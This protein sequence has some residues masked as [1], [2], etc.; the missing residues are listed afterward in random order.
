M[1]DNGIVLTGS[2][3][4]R[5]NW[6]QETGSRGHPSSVEADVL[7]HGRHMTD[8]PGSE[9]VFRHCYEAHYRDVLAY[10]RRRVGHSDAPDA[11]AEVFTVA[12][13]RIEDMPGDERQRAWL[14]GIAYRVIGHKW[15]SRTR[16]SRLKQRVAGVADGAAD[17][18]DPATVVVQRAQDRR[19]RDAAA[20]LRPTDQEILR[21][22][23]WDELPHAEIATIL[24]ISVA[25]VDQRFHRAK[26]RLAREYERMSRGGDAT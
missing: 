20:R 7:P 23:G 21:L 2:A 11:A 17:S 15:R 18:H 1:P 5:Y 25:A 16:Y 12:W 26:K 8:R 3:R 22:A 19:V 13:R 24:G 4:L 9:A 10:C 6:C 14:L